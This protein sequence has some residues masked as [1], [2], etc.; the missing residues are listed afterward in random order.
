[1]A[2]REDSLEVGSRE[3]LT[4]STQ[5]DGNG[6]EIMDHIERRNVKIDT[7]EPVTIVESSPERFKF[8]VGKAISI[9]SDRISLPQQVAVIVRNSLGF[10]V[11]EVKKGKPRTFPRDS[12]I[13]DPG[14][15]VKVYLSFDST[16]EARVTEGGIQIDFDS[17]TKVHVGAR[18]HH[19]RP[20]T[21][22]TTSPEINDVMEAVSFF[23]SSLKTTSCE[24][25]YPTLRGHPPALN[26][27]EKLSIPA[28]LDKPTTDI[29]LELPKDLQSIFTAA[30]LAYY[31]GA[32]VEPGPDPRVVTDDGFVYDLGQPSQ[33]FEESVEQ[34]QKQ[35]FFLDCLTRTEGY[36]QVNLHERNALKPEIDLDFESLY[37]KPVSEQVELYLQVPYER[38]EKYIPKWKLT[39]HVSPHPTY[40][41]TLPYLVN[42]LAVI[43]TVD[44]DDSTMGLKDDFSAS[45]APDT[46]RVTVSEN[47][48]IANS[49]PPTICIHEEDSMEQIWLGEGAPIGAS[50]GMIEAFN[51]R[52]G[53]SPSDTDIDITVICNASEMRREEDIVD[54][55]Y[56]SRSELTFNVSIY[57]DLTT[58]EMRSALAENI[59]FL[60]YIGH[61]DADGFECSNGRLDVADIDRVGVDMFLLNAC[62]SYEQGIELIK[63]GSIAGV[64]TLQDVINSG[65]ERVGLTLA[66]LLNSGFP[67]RPAMNIARSESIMGGHYLVVGDGSVDIAQPQVGLQGLC[68]LQEMA[69]EWL[70]TFTSFP[71][72][73]RGLGS[74]MTPHLDNHDEFYLVSGSTNQLVLD[75]EELIDFLSVE[76]MPIRYDGRLTWSKKLIQQI[77]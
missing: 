71:T 67:L 26:L 22:I 64:V 40:L 14:A 76:E 24:R 34:V 53:R 68:D 52:L 9:E 2:I 38:I 35:V 70:L 74:I 55:V 30:S 32:K 36:F 28:T 39:G 4:F 63:A 20:A 49:K 17:K 75:Q 5:K 73:D 62:S 61:I 50:K 66:Q 29:T 37:R 25:S 18:S 59:D 3:F 19:K 48:N 21:T 15:P 7:E 54:D 6:L 51:N 43:K 57:R 44:I 69:D 60:H 8:P 23:S 10:M 16:F 58:N 72:R 42:D 27:G 31:L 13:L 65:A 47:G 12:Y 45:S 46:N 11:A 1:M 41:E 77:R 33:N 56:G